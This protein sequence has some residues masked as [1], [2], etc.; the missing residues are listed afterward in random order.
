MD[1]FKVKLTTKWNEFKVSQGF[2]NITASLL[3]ILL[4][5]LLGIIIILITNIGNSGLGISRLLL[6]AFNN[7][8]G[9]WI[10][11]G[12]L[13]Y[14]VTPLVFTG[15]AV[16]FA[17]KTGVFNIGASGQYTMGLFVAAIVGIL[18]DNLGFMQWPIALLAGGLAGALW[19][20]LSGVFKALFNVNI[21]ISGIM[22]NYI[23][24]FLVN[25]ML[26]GFLR[27]YMVD[28][29]QNRTITVDQAAR[30]PYAFLDKIF[31]NSGLDFGI[32]L[33]IGFVVLIWFV[34]NKTVFGRELKSVGMNRDAAKY[35]GVNEKRAIILSMAI[36]GFLAGIGGALFILAPS[37]RNLGNQYSLENVILGAGFDGIPIALLG[38]SHP[39]GVFF[40]ALFVQYIK[41]SGDP[42]QSLGYASEIVNLIIAV[43]LYFSAFA[44]IISQYVTKLRKKKNNQVNDDS[45]KDNGVVPP[46]KPSKTEEVIL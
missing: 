34:L 37:I 11:I 17:F 24:M 21:V 4:G 22:L 19:G 7:P 39:V 10:G 46:E 38:N 40:A 28:G 36:A 9:A 25:G 26:G 6:G 15:L 33:A 1:N 5:I 2:K 35:A 8:R 45:N 16:A 23:G 12:Q 44:L 31:P 42:M 32:I 3:A 41:L 18:G 20:A 29:A 30:T 14:R 27:P 13:L 43:I